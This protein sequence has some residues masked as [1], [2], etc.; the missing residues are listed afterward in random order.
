MPS[1]YTYQ[2]QPRGTETSGRNQ[3]DPKRIR[4]QRR[5]PSLKQFSP[6]PTPSINN[7]FSRREEIYNAPPPVDPLVQGILT[8]LHSTGRI[9]DTKALMHWI[10]NNLGSVAEPENLQA[11]FEPANLQPVFNQGD[12]V[13]GHLKFADCRMNLHWMEIPLQSQWGKESTSRII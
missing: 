5:A 8:L 12:Q 13:Y 9:P 2:K 7:P 10:D 3:L 1:K 4:P 6:E 11:V